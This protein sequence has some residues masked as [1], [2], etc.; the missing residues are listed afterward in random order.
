MKNIFKQLLALSLVSSAALTSSLVQA[1]DVE[2]EIKGIKSDSGK[3]YIQIFKGEEN[4]TQGNAE[5]SSIMKAVKGSTKTIFNNMP[6]GE[7]AVRFFHDENSNG[8]LETN[9]FGVPTEGYGFS[10]NAKPNFGPVNYSEIKF[11]VSATDNT[12]KNQTTAIY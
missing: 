10:N 5:S 7:Y 6:V 9:L 4:Y 3:I 2:F 1:S 12:V 8:K 11:L